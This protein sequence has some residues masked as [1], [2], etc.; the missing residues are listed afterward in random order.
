MVASS[1]GVGYRL[2]KAAVAGSWRG[3]AACAGGTE[4]AAMP[5]SYGKGRR[6]DEDAIDVST[7]V[8]NPQRVSR[9]PQ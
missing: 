9:V 5:R 7:D 3:T 1:S 6:V 8:K 4:R 2:D